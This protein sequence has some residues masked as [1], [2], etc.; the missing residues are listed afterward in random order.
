MVDLDDVVA[1]ARYLADVYAE[2][3]PISPQ[4]TPSDD[5]GVRDTTEGPLQRGRQTS[6][7]VGMIIGRR[8]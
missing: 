1:C 2:R 4:P 8:R 6:R 3:S 7:T 5:H